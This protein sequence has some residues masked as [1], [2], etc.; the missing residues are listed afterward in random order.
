MRPEEDDPFDY[1]TI[2]TLREEQGSEF[3]SSEE[4]GPTTAGTSQHKVQTNFPACP[5][6]LPPRPA[7][8]LSQ[9]D[10]STSAEVKS[11]QGQ[12]KVANEGNY[13]VCNMLNASSQYSKASSF[14]GQS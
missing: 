11:S 12:T 6:P 3:Y 2:N 4:E 8:R 14:L 5:P 10:H 13:G 1:I 9:M 7:R